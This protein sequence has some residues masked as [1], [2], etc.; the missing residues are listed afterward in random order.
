[1]QF[2]VDL[3]NSP[4]F[5]ECAFS[6]IIICIIA[7]VLVKSGLLTIHTR[8]VSMGIEDR[9]RNI[10]RKQLIYAKQSCQAFERFIP[11]MDG[12]NVWRG[13]CVTE[14]VY[15]EMVDWIALNHIEANDT[16]ITIKQNAIWNIIQSHVEKPEH[17]TDEFKKVV[18]DRVCSDIKML[19]KIR[20]ESS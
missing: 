14:Y 2:L 10:L 12:Y 11:R 18:F 13:R 5:M 9:E 1:M 8:F 15:D 20:K 7:W 3:V 19:V 16:Y 6:V 4:N 17:S